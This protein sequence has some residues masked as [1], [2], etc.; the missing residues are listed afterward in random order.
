MQAAGFS[1][2][3]RR[4]TEKNAAGGSF[5]GFDRR[6]N[7]AAIQGFGWADARPLSRGSAAQFEI[8][9]AGDT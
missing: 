9:P 7:V 8:Q 5:N 6:M 4:A 2:V 1:S 3:N